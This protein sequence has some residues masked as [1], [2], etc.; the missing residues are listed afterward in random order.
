MAEARWS[1]WTSGIIGRLGGG[2]PWT[3]LR[4]TTSWESAPATG[5]AEEE[6]EQV[7]L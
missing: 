2:S 4:L 6:K 5:I 1:G 3:G 7:S